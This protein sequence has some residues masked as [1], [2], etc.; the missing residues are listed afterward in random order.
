MGSPQRE[1]QGKES[2]QVMSAIDDLAIKLARTKV[3]EYFRV[4]NGKRVKV[5]S[6]DRT[7]GK[8]AIASIAHKV[9][10]AP[11]APAPEKPLVRKPAAPKKPAPKGTPAK[12]A[13]KAPAKAEGG[14]PLDGPEK[15]K[16]V[17]TAAEGLKGSGT[18][19]DPY[20][21]D[22]AERAAE[23]LGQNKWVQL[24]QE[25]TVST[26]LDRLAAIVEEAKEKGD[27]APTYDLCKVTVPGTNLFCVE[28][29]G[30]PRI[31]MPQLGGIATKG[32]KA[33]K[34]PKD[35]RGEVDI[36]QQFLQY[37]I[38]D[39]GIGVTND[40]VDAKYLK[41]SQNELNG[42]KVA[43]IAGAIEAGKF[44][45]SRGTLFVSKDDYIVDGHHR[46]AAQVAQSIK[47]GKPSPIKT[48]VIDT[49]IITLLALA[50][51]FAAEWGIAQQGVG[52]TPKPKP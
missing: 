16:F 35:S 27:K 18:K 13:P 3:K 1:E 7:G 23:L 39:Q 34:L 17:P 14:G 28:S 29:K 20:Q 8:G 2:G 43:G 37:V 32:S 15:P 50:N 10:K 21:T 22:S 52:E 51:N 30:I 48:R 49:D 6:H 19:E 41:A 45:P 5:S 11:Q 36:S 44:D 26:L 40:E 47:T 9:T 24:D 25:R 31:K 4:V 38:E 46:W 42:G 12:A 33:D